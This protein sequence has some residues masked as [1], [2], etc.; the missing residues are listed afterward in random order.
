MDIRFWHIIRKAEPKVLIMR[1]NELKR[2]EVINICDGKRLGFVG[3]I[4]FHICTGKIEFLIVPGPGCFCGFLGHEKE[5]RIPCRDIC[6]IGNDVILVKIN[7]K[8]NE[9]SHGPKRG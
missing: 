5:Y 1:M 7:E 8:E 9:K 4:E 2:M 3:D 6:Q